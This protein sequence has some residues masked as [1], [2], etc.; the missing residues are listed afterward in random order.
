MADQRAGVVL[1]VQRHGHELQC[2]DP[3]FG[4]GAQIGDL[5]VVQ[6]EAADPDQ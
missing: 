6:V 5:R 3:P 2:G 4:A 1:V